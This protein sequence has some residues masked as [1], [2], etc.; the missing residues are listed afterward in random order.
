MGV[1]NTVALAAL[2]AALAISQALAGD[3]GE[4]SDMRAVL[5]VD[6]VPGDPEYGEYLVQECTACHVA[7]GAGGVPPIDGIAPGYFRLAMI[8]YA[9]GTRDNAVM[10]S[11]ARSL[12]DEELAALAAW[13][14]TQQEKQD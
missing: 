3:G 13:F 10:V 5:T 14:A 2:C 7:D 9:D 11:V 4:M 8:E 12:G 1:L 6:G